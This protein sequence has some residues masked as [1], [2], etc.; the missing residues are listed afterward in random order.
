[1][2]GIANFLPHHLISSTNTHNRS[3]FAVGTDDGLSHTVAAQLVQ[4][5]KGTFTSRYEYD[6][7]FCQLIGV[8]GIK[9][10]NTRVAFQHIEIGK[11]AEMAQQD[12]GYIDFTQFGLHRFCGKGKGVFFFDIYF[13]I[14]RNNPY[15]RNAAKFFE[16]LDAGLEQADIATE[17]ID[18]NTLNAFTLVRAK[19][20]QRTVDTGKDTAPVDVSHKDNICSGMQGHRKIYQI[21]V[22]QVY[23][24]NASGTFH[25][26]RIVAG[27]QT[28]V[29]GTD[30]ATQFITAFG[31]EIIVGITVTDGTAVEHN[32]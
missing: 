16:H 32:L 28:V 18:K 23:F 10:M 30:F 7:G 9:K 11:I 1:M 14:I 26:H 24:G 8:V 2:V 4:V 21:S 5:G 27:R 19:Q 25:H 17:L 22:P 15:H 29:C 3:S 13:L 6:I 12:N 31:T 20:Q